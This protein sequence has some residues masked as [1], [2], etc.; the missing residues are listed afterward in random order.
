MNMARKAKTFGQE[1]LESAHE[2]IAIARGEIEPARAYVPEKVDV[3]AI[4]AK[5][6]LS[7]AKFAERYGI[8]IGTLR[9]W[10]QDRRQPDQPARVLLSIIERNHVAIAHMLDARTGATVVETERPAPASMHKG[11]RA[12]NR[13]TV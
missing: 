5:T 2:A 4:R 7:Q 6:R 8:P 12:E 11:K 3:P 1:L 10:E 13:N 9:D